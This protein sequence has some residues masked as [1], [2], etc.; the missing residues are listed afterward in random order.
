MNSA[1]LFAAVAPYLEQFVHAVGGFQVFVAEHDENAISVSDAVH[2]FGNAV[3]IAHRSLV[4]NDFY[5]FLLR[6]RAELIHRSFPLAALRR[7]IVPGIG[8][9]IFGFG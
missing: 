5:A 9:E 3:A 2:E 7:V 6:P 1:S 4:A 8:D